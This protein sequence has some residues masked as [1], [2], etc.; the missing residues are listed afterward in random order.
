MVELSEIGIPI[1]LDEMIKSCFSE[2]KATS[3]YSSSSSSVPGVAMVHPIGSP[4]TA[5]ARSSKRLAAATSST[6]NDGKEQLSGF[7]GECERERFSYENTSL[8]R[9]F[10]H[11]TAEQI[12]QFS[13]ASPITPANPDF[14]L[15]S[16]AGRG[17]GGGGSVMSMKI[18]FATPSSLP[19][20]ITHSMLGGGGGGAG[21]ATGGGGG[22]RRTGAAGG[23]VGAHT[24]NQTGVRE[25]LAETPFSDPSANSGHYEYHYPYPYTSSSSLAPSTAPLLPSSEQQ[26][27]TIGR[28]DRERERDRNGGGDLRQQARATLFGLPTPATNE[29]ESESSSLMGSIDGGDGRGLTDDQSR[30]MELNSAFRTT[31]AVASDRISGG[32]GGMGG[33]GGDRRRV[34]FGPTA[35]L[36][37][38]GAM[39]SSHLPPSSASAAAPPPPPPAP[40][41]SF[42][43]GIGV[44][45]AIEDSSSGSAAGGGSDGEGGD[46]EVSVSE[47][48]DEED[49]GNSKIITAEDKDDYPYKL[50]RAE[51]GKLFS[52]S[53]SQKQRKSNNVAFPTSLSL[54]SLSPFPLSTINS[55][56]ILPSTNN[57]AEDGEADTSSLLYEE[58]QSMIIPDHHE[59][60]G[61]NISSSHHDRKPMTV[62]RPS[63]S[64]KKQSSSE[65]NEERSNHHQQH[66]QQPTTQKGNNDVSLER[67]KTRSTSYD[68][69]DTILPIVVLFARSL[70]QLYSYYCV[71]AIQTLQKLPTC[72]YQSAFVNQIIGKACVEMNEYKAAIIA[73]NEMRRLE[74]WRIAGLE[75]MSIALWHLREEKQL[76]SLAQQVC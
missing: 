34:S 59:E 74:P 76:S 13:T 6:S 12:K 61:S 53:P 10:L 54:P 50:Q 20:P 40:L 68:Q 51:G 56:H 48:N 63:S 27:S 31:A 24:V 35:R 11:Q 4:K 23:G 44:R 2:M 29:R 37:F 70:Q 14:S 49:G 52:P 69:S 43:L 16:S 25:P 55:S 72:H 19:S 73:F 28:D 58:S 46:D 60:D 36:S 9:Q 7:E 30:L 15:L 47:V 3:S 57:K 67:E 26:L 64:Q 41:S 65:M 62:V 45:S 8:A 1:K 39:D 33:G 5:P 71:E 42:S 75:I 32:T 38:S 22:G 21:N 17:G 18:P 66:Q